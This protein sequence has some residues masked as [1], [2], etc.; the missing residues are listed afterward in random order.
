MLERKYD[1]TLP[2]RFA[3]YGRMSGDRQNKR[4]PDQQFFTI[5]ETLKRCGY[6]W[7]CIATYRD[8]AISGRYLRKRPGLQRMLCDIEVGLI[9][10]D[11]I[12]VDTL[13]RFARA[14]EM[15]ELRRKLFIEFGVLVVA[16]DNNFADP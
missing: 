7:Q 14:E 1:P 11:V 8:D 10:I 13:E 4:S 15:A 5:D 2:F 3:C 16:A 6:P 12:A 9:R